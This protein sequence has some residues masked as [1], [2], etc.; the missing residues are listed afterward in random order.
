MPLKTTYLL[1]TTVIHSIFWLIQLIEDRCQLSCY[2]SFCFWTVCNEE[3]TKTSKI[4]ALH[5]SQWSNLYIYLLSRDVGCLVYVASPT[6]LPLL[7]AFKKWDSRVIHLLQ[8][9]RQIHHRD[10]YLHH[11]IEIVERQAACGWK[12][13]LRCVNKHVF[14]DPRQQICVTNKEQTVLTTNQ[15]FLLFDF[16]SCLCQEIF[17]LFVAVRN[18]TLKMWEVGV[19]VLSNLLPGIPFIPGWNSCAAFPS[20]YAFFLLN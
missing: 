17:P 18:C 13:K 8:N 14:K 1:L 11:R 3:L 2:S 16:L 12:I 6:P 19:D 10:H 15:S 5:I 20:D 4:E 9:T 7:L